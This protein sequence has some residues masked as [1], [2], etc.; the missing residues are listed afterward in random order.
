MVDLHV[1]TSLDQL[2]T[3]KILFTLFLK[4]ATLI[5]R[6]TLLS[7]P[8]L[9]GLTLTPDNRRDDA[10]SATSTRPVERRKTRNFDPTSRRC[11]D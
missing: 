11:E 8:L 3:L 4:Q 9:K 6:S 5:R 7:L 10:A 2:L 1:L